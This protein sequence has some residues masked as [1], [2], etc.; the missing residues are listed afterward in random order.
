MNAVI[1]SHGN[2]EVIIPYLEGRCSQCLQEVKVRRDP[3]VNDKGKIVAAAGLMSVP[4][5]KVLIV[6]TMIK[7]CPYVRMADGK[8]SVSD[9]PNFE[10]VSPMKEGNQ[11]EETPANEDKKPEVKEKILSF[12]SKSIHA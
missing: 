2:D 5:L 8:I 10:A 12:V 3:I 9:C 6:K 1:F 11:S 4:A 7:E